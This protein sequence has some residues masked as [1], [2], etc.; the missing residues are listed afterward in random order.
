[1]SPLCPGGQHHALRFNTAFLILYVWRSARPQRETWCSCGRPH[2]SASHFLLSSLN[3]WTATAS[4]SLLSIY[5]SIRVSF[6]SPLFLHRFDLMWYFYCLLTKGFYQ[7]ICYCVLRQ[8]NM[9]L[10]NV[11][12]EKMNGW[13]FT[14]V[15][16]LDFLEISDW[17]TGKYDF[18]YSR[19]SCCSLICSLRSIDTYLL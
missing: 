5:G 18:T 10:R 4:F 2:E 17:L 13:Y 7:T 6:S 3:S 14:A 12:V 1:M 8:T 11:N 19:I 15:S 16:I 9:V